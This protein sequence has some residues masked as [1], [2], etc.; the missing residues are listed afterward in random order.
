MVQPHAQNSD[1]RR[2]FAWTLLACIV[3]CAVQAGPYFLRRVYTADDL[4]AYHLPMRAFYARCLQQGEPFDWMPDLYCGFYLTG[5]GQAGT[6]H[7][8]HWVLYRFLP[9]RA[10]FDLELLTPYPCMLAGMYLFLRRHVDR[11]WAA[12]FGGLVFTYSA[13]NAL[14]FVHPHAMA[15][16]AHVPWLLWGCDVLL[17]SRGRN[18][19]AAGVAVALLS[20]SQWLLGY[21]Q[22][23]WLSLLVEAGYVVWFARR[24]QEPAPGPPAQLR[25][26]TRWS[27]PAIVGTWGGLKLLGVLLGGVQWLPTL[28]WLQHSDRAASSAAFAGTG[29]QHVANAVQ[30]VAPYLFRTRVLGGNTHE[31]GFY[32]GAVP[33]VLIAWMAREGSLGTKDRAFVKAAIALAVVALWLSLGRVAGLYELQARVPVLNSFRLPARYLL[34]VHLAASCLAAVAA[35]HFAARCGAATL[36]GADAAGHSCQR[37]IR[38][39]PSRQLRSVLVLSLFVA[40]GAWLLIDRRYLAAPHLAFAGPALIALALWLMDSAVR[41]PQWALPAM[42]CFTAADLAVYGA[43]YAMWPATSRLD[44]VYQGIDAPA[45]P[46][47]GRLV[48]DALGPAARQGIRTGNEVLLR[49]WSRADGYAGLEPRSAA[50][51]DDVSETW[52][53]IAGVR[54]VRAVAGE[55][56]GE[57]R[58]DAA[59]ST[60][61]AARWREI[62]DVLPRAWCVSQAVVVR[63]PARALPWIEPSTMAVVEQPVDLKPGVAGRSLV[64]ADRPGHIALFVQCPTRQLLAVNERFHPGWQVRVG[65]QVQPVQ[66]VYGEFLG[67]VVEPGAQHVVFDFQPAS[68]FVGHLV[69]ACGLTCV[70]LC[71]LVAVIHRGRRPQPRSLRWSNV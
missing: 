14:H 62:P 26:A 31:L 56:R 36:A 59:A 41:R 18:R 40:A 30:L 67:C 70:L 13:F 46:P 1:D 25:L 68:L 7:P 65:G 52:L 34:L 10:A 35:A 66:R 9:L 16:V 15:I 58:T 69:S 28:D 42:V 57:A 45:A 29:A 49:G 38:R 19:L 48:A 4:L 3:V 12:L 64:V 53:R 71:S 27:L 39:R 47:Q 23:V 63:E 51:G 37:P 24:G 20:G 5:E 11:R 60:A 17:C 54:W 55:P 50:A 8:W 21:P 44:E 2:L 22:Y 32:L 43:S 33:L 6:Y 61:Q